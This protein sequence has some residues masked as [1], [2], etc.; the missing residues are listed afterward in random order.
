MKTGNGGWWYDS[1][2][3]A[4]ATGLYINH[5]AYAKDPID[6]EGKYENLKGIVWRTAR[7]KYS[8]QFYSFEPTHFSI[9]N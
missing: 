2:Q 4:K 5:Y 1:C 3:A 8:Q 7:A 9:E 6:V